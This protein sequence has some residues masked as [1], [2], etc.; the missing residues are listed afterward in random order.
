V[1]LAG[2][3][4]YPDQDW[5]EQQARNITM[6][7]WGCL[8]GCR[9]LLHDRDTKFCESFRELI[10]TGNVD[11][12]RLPARSP[13][14]NSYAERWVRSVKEE[15][16]AKLILVG[17]S[18]LRRAL[19]QYLLHYHEERN[20][21][22]KE[23]RI[24][25]P[26]PTKARRKEGAVQCRERLGGPAEI[27]RARGSIRVSASQQF[28]AKGF[29]ISGCVSLVL[30]ALKLTEMKQW[31]WWR[32]FLPLWVI[33]GQ[34]VIYV[35]VGF[36][37][38]FAVRDREDEEAEE[39]AKVQSDRLVYQVASLVCVLIA[40]DNLLRWLERGGNSYWFWLCSGSVAM[41]VLF[42][43]LALVAQF[44]Y[45]AEI[46]KGLND[47]LVEGNGRRDID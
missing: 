40:M 19:R 20:H 42:G 10:E 22:G 14:L 28:Q 33:V 18:S 38:L 11:P 29:Y 16:L 32:V 6:E 31:S 15:C 21:Q 5:M 34:N 43:I 30:A 8:R 3:T 1:S 47:Q 36:L 25:F 46:I 27:L 26:F 45:W 4:P 12:L 37:C 23:N 17:E 13:N 35:L 2:F 44:F 39:P 9:Y 24:L 7:Q 41:V